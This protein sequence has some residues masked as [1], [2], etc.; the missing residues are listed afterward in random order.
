MDSPPEQNQISA[1]NH[2]LQ[3]KLTVFY[4]FLHSRESSVQYD[5]SKFSLKKVVDANVLLKDQF[6][7]HQ[8]TNTPA[9]MGVAA[10]E[11]TRK[12]ISFSK[13]DVQQ[14]RCAN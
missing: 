12:A 2:E 7:S 14:K 4:D 13:L 6:Q 3:N 10:M 5:I 8:L 9:L 11:A 1:T